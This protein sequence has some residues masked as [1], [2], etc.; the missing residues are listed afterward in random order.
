MSWLELSVS[1]DQEGAEA[2]YELFSRY[3]AGRTA[4]VELMAEGGGQGRD[5][6]PSTF[7]VRGY[8]PLDGREEEL[9]EHIREGLWHLGQ[10]HPL[11]ELEAAKIQEDDWLQLWRKD[12]H[13][14]RIGQRIVIVPS[15]EPY[16]ARPGEAAFVLDPGLAF[17]TGLHPSTRTCLIALEE[18]LAAGTR[19]LDV[20]TGSGILALAAA[21]LGAGSV[22]AVDTDP[23]AV[24]VA[25]GNIAANALE[26]LIQ[27]RQGSVEVAQEAGPFGMALANI[28][29][30]V[31][32]DLSPQLARLLSPGGLL[33]GGG[34]LKEKEAQVAEAFQGQGLRAVA[35]WQEGDWIALAGRKET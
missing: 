34:I 24:K 10:V 12:Y 30:E 11:G 22:L 20:G 25:R 23:V 7:V 17:G 9:A 27:A 21:R 8:L 26:A 6:P 31:V 32:I 1:A 3:T 5:A 18:H 16:Q 29:A 19:V 15:W 13:I 14:Q 33:I 35:R 4:G 28:L 2:V